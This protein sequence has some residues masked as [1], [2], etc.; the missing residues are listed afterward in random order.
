[1]PIKEQKHQIL[2]DR[3]KAV[4]CYSSGSTRRTASQ[5][6]QKPSTSHSA[7]LLESPISPVQELE[8]QPLHW[9]TIHY[10]ASAQRLATHSARDPAL[11]TVVQ[12][13]P[14]SPIKKQELQH[15]HWGEE[16]GNLHHNRNLAKGNISNIPLS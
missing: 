14:H 9:V 16:R 3:K 11:P 12:E 6:T 1:L 15:P 8:S 5:G 13:S 10:S 2:H 7:S 4:T